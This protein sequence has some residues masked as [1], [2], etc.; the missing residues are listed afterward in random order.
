MGNII[1]KL[2]KA[3][4][5]KCFNF[6]GAKVKP[7]LSSDGCKRCMFE[8]EEQADGCKFRTACMAHC[9]VDNKSVVF[10]NGK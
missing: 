9:R 4:V 5:G 1:E 6:S 8:T 10:V 2:A 3:K 7:V